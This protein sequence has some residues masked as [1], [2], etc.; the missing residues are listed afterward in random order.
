MDRL[1]LGLGASFV[2][3][4]A[5]YRWPIVP[6]WLAS[7][8]FAIGIGLL[9]WAAMPFVRTGPAI[10]G[11]AALVALA[12]AVEWQG[13]F[14]PAA[15]PS[16]AP[17]SPSVAPSEPNV[18]TE[19]HVDRRATTKP[20]ASLATKVI[21]HAP[22]DDLPPA[23]DLTDGRVV[24]LRQLTQLYMLSHDGITPRMMAGLEYPPADFLNAE[25][26]KLGE[27]WRVRDADAGKVQ[28]YDLP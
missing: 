16:S 21:K 8:G 27:R 9:L 17:P 13:S 7:G 6:K 2:F 3:G 28:I 26:E 15:I 20:E 12:V 25:L 11:I 22:P 1:L 24:R 23:P 4:F 5:R 10:L 14:R 19:T 18:R